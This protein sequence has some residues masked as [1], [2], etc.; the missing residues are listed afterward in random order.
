M[1]LAMLAAILN[2]EHLVKVSGY[3]LLFLLVMAESS[4]AADP[5]GDGADRRLGAGQR[6]NA[7]DRGGDRARRRG[8]DRGGQHRLPDRAQGRALAARTARRVPGPAPAGAGHGASRSS[9]GTARRPCSSGASCSA[10]GCGPPGWRGPPTCHGARSWCGTPSAGSCWAVVIGHDRLRAG[11]LRRQRAGSL[12]P[13]GPDRGGHRDR[14]LLR[15]APAQPPPRRSAGPRSGWMVRERSRRAIAGTRRDRRGG[16]GG[17]SRRR[18]DGSH[19]LRAPSGGRP[20]RELL[21]GRLGAAGR[22]DQAS[23]WPVQGAIR[24]HMS[25]S[26]S[27]SASLKC[28]KN[29]WRTTARCVTRA[30]SRRSRPASVRQA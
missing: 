16:R 26:R 3:P 28:E 7:A 21:P 8:R 14:G 18:A 10:C 15:V 11:Q 29:C 1:A 2:V 30:A 5:R 12:R 23:W 20:G 25:A 19:D 13:V 24:S 4:R 9:N 22:C 6:G 27:S 17:R